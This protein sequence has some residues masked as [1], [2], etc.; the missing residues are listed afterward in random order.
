MTE[1]RIGS[2]RVKA[3]TRF[4]IKP[5][6]RNGAKVSSTPIGED[7]LFSETSSSDEGSPSANAKPRQYFTRQRARLRSIARSKAVGA[8]S[9][10]VVDPQSRFRVVN[11]G[12]FPWH[13]HAVDHGPFAFACRLARRRAAVISDSSG[14]SDDSLYGER[15]MTSQASTPAAANGD[16]TMHDRVQPQ[17]DYRLL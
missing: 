4:I 14:D 9:V 12:C 5:R 3:R 13:W 2:N 17:G 6:Q 16:T 7:A 1:H 10:K 11:H 8:R 15:S